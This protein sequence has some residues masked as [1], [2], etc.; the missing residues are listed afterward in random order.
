M[1][2]TSMGHRSPWATHQLSLLLHHTIITPHCTAPLGCPGPQSQFYSSG[3]P[4]ALCH[5]GTH[6]CRLPSLVGYAVLVPPYPLGQQQEMD[7]GR[8]AQLLLQLEQQEKRWTEGSLGVEWGR[9]KGLQI[10][11][12]QAACT[13]CPAS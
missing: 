5:A 8:G 7:T 1:G 2:H 4:A 12:L 11:S 9:E 13:L 6:G 10:N 3:I